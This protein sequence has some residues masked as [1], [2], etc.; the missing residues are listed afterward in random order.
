MFKHG[1]ELFLK[2]AIILFSGVFS[3][4]DRFFE[5]TYV[6]SGVV[7]MLFRTVFFSIFGGSAYTPKPTLIYIQ[8]LHIQLTYLIFNN[9]PRRTPAL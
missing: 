9:L 8:L 6:V 4:S 2:I 3:S 7:F 1:F 5:L